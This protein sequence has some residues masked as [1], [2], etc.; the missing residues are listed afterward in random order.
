MKALPP[1]PPC[2]TLFLVTPCANRMFKPVPASL[3]CLFQ[4]A[5]SGKSAWADVTRILP[6]EVFPSGGMCMLWDDVGFRLLVRGRGGGGSSLFLPQVGLV[7]VMLRTPR[8]LHS[9]AQT[10]GF[11]GK[12]KCSYALVTSSRFSRTE[13]SKYEDRNTW[14][15]NSLVSTHT[16]RIGGW[17][18]RSEC[19]GS[20]YSTSIFVHRW[21]KNK[22]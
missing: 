18:I 7:G 2:R 13:W 19:F 17:I 15:P 14:I 3:G 20:F 9:F 8:F 4:P 16:P 10:S 1:L 11:V 5:L 12:E 6:A 22:A 21:E